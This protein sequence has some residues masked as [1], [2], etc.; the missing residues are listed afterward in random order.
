M[1]NRTFVVILIV[2]LGLVL[3]AVA[4]HT[5]GGRDIVRSLHGGR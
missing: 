5:P 1:N 3:A 2:A 4:F